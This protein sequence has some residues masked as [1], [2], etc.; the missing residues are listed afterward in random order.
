L[1]IDELLARLRALLKTEK[2]WLLYAAGA[3][4]IMLIAVTSLPEAQRKPVPPKARMAQEPTITIHIVATKETRKLLLEEYVA[5]AVAG[6]MRNDW[7]LEALKAQAIVARTF[8][9]QRLLSEVKS[10]FG[11]DLST[12]PGEALPYDSTRVNPAIS[13]AVRQTRGLVLTYG[14]NPILA[15][16]HPCSGGKTATA[17]EGL[18]VT[19]SPTPYLTVV[20]DDP[21]SAADLEN[22]QASFPVADVARELGIGRFT[23]ASIVSRGPSG[24]AWTVLLGSKSV[25]A[26][27]LRNLLGPDK[28]KSTLLT[29]FKVVEGELRMTGKGS[30]HGVGMSQWGARDRA[31]RGETARAILATYYPGTLVEPFWP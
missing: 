19:I 7:P 13:T 30:G 18:G 21:C 11:T 6:Q 29:S 12:D 31:A 4:L 23:K 3:I 9:V 24:R 28:M 25:G 8:A 26:V 17:P 10:R 15:F 5:G 22:W 16:F 20:T 1:D 2:R 27:G 14:G